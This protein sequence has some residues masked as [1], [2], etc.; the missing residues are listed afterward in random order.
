MTMVKLKLMAIIM[1][2]VMRMVM[3]A[4]SLL[5]NQSEKHVKWNVINDG[6]HH[7]AEAGDEGDEDDGDEDE[8]EDGDENLL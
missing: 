1:M 6:N 5:L 4:F 2:R 7:D 8:D 3:E